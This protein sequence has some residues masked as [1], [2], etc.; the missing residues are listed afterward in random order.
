MFVG[1]PACALDSPGSVALAAFRFSASVHCTNH[2]SGWCVAVVALRRC[3]LKAYA[4]AKVVVVFSLVA[5]IIMFVVVGTLLF[6]VAVV[7]VKF[8]VVVVFIIFCFCCF[9]RLL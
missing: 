6:F 7:A 9:M 2:S 8:F 3:A 4:K 5:I 1:M